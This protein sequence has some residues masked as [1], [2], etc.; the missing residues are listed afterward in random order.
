MPLSTCT[1]VKCTQ[2][3]NAFILV[4]N[5]SSKSYFFLIACLNKK[6]K[7]HVRNI[8][9]T[10]PL[11]CD[12]WSPGSRRQHR[13]SHPLCPPRPCSWGCWGRLAGSTGWSLGCSSTGSW[14]LCWSEVTGSCLQPGFT[15][16]RIRTEI[17][18]ISN[19][20]K[21]A[22]RSLQAK[23]GKMMWSVVYKDTMYQFDYNVFTMTPVQPTV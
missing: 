23:A 9:L 17:M 7:N 20:S 5:M 8:G 10:S 1:E 16:R 22:G 4:N 6:K 18:S 11:C 21:Y 2:A 12:V 13:C 19:K 14:T 3:K 15:N